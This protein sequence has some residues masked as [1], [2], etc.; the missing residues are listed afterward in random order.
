MRR[1]CANESFV[2]LLQYYR[3]PQA[4]YYPAQSEKV[5]RL[6]GRRAISQQTDVDVPRRTML[7]NAKGHLAA[8][9][10]SMILCPM[11]SH[12]NPDLNHFQALSFSDLIGVF[13]NTRRTSLLEIEHERH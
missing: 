6:P 1:G 13:C 10:S 11:L 9:A 8:T 5:P 2:H 7:Y 4:K 3:L 12:V